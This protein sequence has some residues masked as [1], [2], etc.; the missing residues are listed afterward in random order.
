MT[1][2]PALSA[3]GA[4]LHDLYYKRNADNTLDV[5]LANSTNAGLT[6][7]YERVSG[8]SFPGVFTFPQFDPVIAPA[9]MGD[10]IANTSDGTNQYFAWGDNRNIVTNFLWPQGRHD[11]DVYFARRG[12]QSEGGGNN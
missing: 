2:Q 12:G 6:W 8:Q 10:Y 4:G 9:Y 1:R 11:P 5:L 3:D 7:S